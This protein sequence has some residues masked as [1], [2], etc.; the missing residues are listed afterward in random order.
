MSVQM[1]VA[2]S[3]NRGR[4]LQRHSSYRALRA[5]DVEE[6]IKQ[7]VRRAPSNLFLSLPTASA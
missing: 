7:Q 4:V 6:I 5:A 3:S 2:S 1:G